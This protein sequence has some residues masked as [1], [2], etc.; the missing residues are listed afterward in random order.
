MAKHFEE[1]EIALKRSIAKKR[2]LQLDNFK[3]HKQGDLGPMDFGFSPVDKWPE[4][5]LEFL[6]WHELDRDYYWRSLDYLEEL[7]RRGVRLSEED[8]RRYTETCVEQAFEGREVASKVPLYYDVWERFEADNCLLAPFIT[9]KHRR[10]AVNRGFWKALRGSVESAVD[11]YDRALHR[12]MRYKEFFHFYDFR[13]GSEKALEIPDNLELQRSDINTYLRWFLVQEEEIFRRFGH[14]RAVG[15]VGNLFAP[16]VQ[17]LFMQ[18]EYDKRTARIAD[19]FTDGELIFTPGVQRALKRT[20]EIE[21]DSAFWNAPEV[22]FRNIKV[23][24]GNLKGWERVVKEVWERAKEHGRRFE[25]V[26]LEYRDYLPEEE[27]EDYARGVRE[28]IEGMKRFDVGLYRIWCSQDTLKR[29]SKGL[30]GKIKNNA[31]R[32]YRERKPRPKAEDLRSL[33]SFRLDNLTEGFLVMDLLAKRE[34]NYANDIL[35]KYRVGSHEMVRM[36]VAT[37][38]Q[39]DNFLRGTKE[40]VEIHGRVTVD[41][42]GLELRACF[43]KYNKIPD[44]VRGYSEQDK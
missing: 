7:N 22:S 14:E 20:L 42:G 11:D 18:A 13:A 25:D 5:C 27:Y 37:R 26:P 32:L 4:E 21:M 43:P 12:I 3:D 41:K 33:S 29:F 39:T 28:Q 23:C 17:R 19:Y 44:F 34:W 2:V 10:E 16:I 35:H 24:V 9:D 36:A 15:V 8:L 38:K 6:V 30:H 40:Y 31:L 1:T